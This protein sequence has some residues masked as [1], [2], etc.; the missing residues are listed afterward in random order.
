MPMGAAADRSSGGGVGQTVD[1]G[2]L[3]GPFWVRSSAPTAHCL[4][5]ILNSEWSHHVTYASCCDWA[6]ADHG[7]LWSDLNQWDRCE[8]L[9]VV[10]LGMRR[11]INGMGAQMVLF[12][13]LPMMAVHGDEFVHGR[14]EFMIW[15]KLLW[16][17]S[18]HEVLDSLNCCRWVAG[19]DDDDDG[20]DE[21]DCLNVLKVAIVDEVHRILGEER[22][23]V[24][25][26]GSDRTIGRRRRWVAQSVC[27]GRWSTEIGTPA[28]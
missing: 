5:W 12:G 7:N 22:V 10:D 18:G 17:R 16:G 4:A 2:W 28:V 26:P 11:W 8:R 15:E 9:L 23:V 3:S 6:A 1:A 21:D 24:L 20:P 13:H 25:L 14:S 19:E 27:W